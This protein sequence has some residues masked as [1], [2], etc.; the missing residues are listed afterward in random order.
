M[1]YIGKFRDIDNNLYTLVII[2]KGDS[3]ITKEIVL[4]DSPVV[5]DYEGSDDIYKPMKY[6]SS[7]IKLITADY[8]E[9]LYSNE[10]ADTTV[11]LYKGNQIK[12]V[13]N[14]SPNIYNQGF[15]YDMEEF[16]I[17]CIDGLSALKYYEYIPVDGVNKN[18]SFIDIINHILQKVGCYKYFY[19]NNNLQAF[20]KGK[21][22]TSFFYANT[23]ISEQNFFDKG[24]GMMM[25]EVLEEICKYCGLTCMTVGDSVYFVDYD[26]LEVDNKYNKYEVGA[27]TGT[28][29]TISIENHVIKGK[30][31][32]ENG[33]QISMG[34]I[35]NNFTVTDSTNTFSNLIPS[36]FDNITNING[37]G[38]IIQVDNEY[39]GQKYK[40]FYKFY[41]NP[42]YK[43]YYYDKNSLKPVDRP[44]GKFSYSDLQNLIGATPIIYYSEKVEQFEDK[45]KKLDFT[46]YLLCH[47]H[48]TETDVFP[49]RPLF[50]LTENL[51]QPSFLGGQTY[52]LIKGN[53]KYFNQPNQMFLIDNLNQGK[54]S[55]GH[56]YLFC[57]LKLGNLW[58]DADTNSWTSLKKYFKLLLDDNG[59]HQ[60]NNNQ[61]S[62]KNNVT[63]DMFLDGEEGYAIKLPYF[64]LGYSMPVKPTLVVYQ[65]RRIDIHS[66]CDAVWLSNFEIK[67]VVSHW[68]TDKDNDSETTYT[69]RTPHSMYAHKFPKETFKICTW[70][71]KSPNYSSPSYLLGNGNYTFLM[72]VYSKGA[73]KVRTPEYL[74]I[75][76]HL[77][78]YKE[79]T[80]VLDLTL[81]NNIIEP[82][83]LFY[84]SYLG[85]EKKF[86]V[87]TQ[88]ID[89]R[90]NSNSVRL[91]QKKQ[92]QYEIEQK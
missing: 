2:S 14:V 27:V 91:V 51:S 29:T 58:W 15:E 7:T 21:K 92:K 78:Q 54:V 87:D 18:K 40:C 57:E 65:P 50:E 63:W 17:E 71:N 88:S 36:I 13:G 67:A 3:S 76:R 33:G 5:T 44:E 72:N 20:I 61:F 11:T 6:S 85:Y 38:K 75:D 56:L 43:Y 86:I 62:V 81:K 64:D 46:K 24:K 60:A 53:A 59:N 74:W 31:Y 39:G 9:D 69:N 22:E 82:F 26:C 79:P 45:P 30:D 16:E 37:E 80:L 77:E 25:N 55:E 89:W 70:D 28:S 84:E 41:K 8:L 1:K 32:A 66:R 19:I 35:F 10:A 73:Q 68:N 48:D 83:K 34:E 12:W 52:I 23:F 42:D 47:C 90:H 4:G 49:N